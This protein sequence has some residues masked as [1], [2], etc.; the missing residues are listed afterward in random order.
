MVVEVKT[1]LHAADPK[2]FVS[3]LGDFREWRTDYARP[4]MYRALGYL[5][6]KGNSTRAAEGF[7][8]ILAVGSSASIV[9]SGGSRPV[10]TYPR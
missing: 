9:N 7:Y 1:T 2:R 4:R 10:S 5:T 3:W 8:L 6:A